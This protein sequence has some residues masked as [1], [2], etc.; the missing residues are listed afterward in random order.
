[1]R[2]SPYLRIHDPDAMTR[3]VADFETTPPSTDPILSQTAA[4][5]SDFSGKTLTT[6]VQILPS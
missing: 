1:M 6:T 5:D 2:I 4:A 3:Y